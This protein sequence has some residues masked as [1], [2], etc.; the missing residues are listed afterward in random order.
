MR[1]SCGSFLVFLQHTDLIGIIRGW[2]YLGFFFFEARVSF[3]FISLISKVPSPVHLFQ[4]NFF[5]IPLS[6]PLWIYTGCFLFFVLFLK[7]ITI[8][9]AL[10]KVSHRIPPFSSASCNIVQFC[11]LCLLLLFTD[12]ELSSSVLPWIPARNIRVCLLY[13]SKFETQILHA[14]SC[15]QS[16]PKHGEMVA[17]IQLICES[18][19]RIR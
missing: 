15:R 2:N 12:A 10:I 6:S 13:F 19:R 5:D 11:L 8:F 3:S 18:M 9:W 17:D 7:E 1:N 16:N 14:S 4:C